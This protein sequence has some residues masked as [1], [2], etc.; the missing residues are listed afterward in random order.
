M[1]DLRFHETKAEHRNRN[2]S[3]TFPEDLMSEAATQKLD[4]SYERYAR[5]RQSKVFHKKSKTDEKRSHK[6]YSPVPEVWECVENG[7]LDKR[8]DGIGTEDTF[9]M[10]YGCVMEKWKGPEGDFWMSCSAYFFSK[11]GEE[12]YA[13]EGNEIHNY[14]PLEHE[15]ASVV[16]WLGASWFLISLQL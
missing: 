16:R 9:R 3:V 14:D 10:Y 11:I 15:H 7:H 12:L 5:G 1:M 8:F 2:V 4:E 13:K 6:G